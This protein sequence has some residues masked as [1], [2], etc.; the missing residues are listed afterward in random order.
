MDQLYSV[1]VLFTSYAGIY[2]HSL[3][4]DQSRISRC[5]AGRLFLTRN[6]TGRR[7]P[8]IKPPSERE[9]KPST[10]YS[11]HSQLTAHTP[12]RLTDS[13][14]SASQL[15]DS[16]IVLGSGAFVTPTAR[17]VTRRDTASRGAT[18]SSP[19]P[20]AAAL[21]T[22]TRTATGHWLRASRVRAPAAPPAAVSPVCIT[23]AGRMAAP[24]SASRPPT[25]YSV[26][27]RRCRRIR[28]V[29]TC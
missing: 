11:P 8:N 9:S 10:A 18:G 17:H 15:T 16:R 4:Q 13:P 12:L 24:P 25:W 26:R 19:Q 14:H 28:R 1:L 5:E 21:G 7:S 29:T 2:G 23:S 3:G 27:N 6:H 20:A 22:I